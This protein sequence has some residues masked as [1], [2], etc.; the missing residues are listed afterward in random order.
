M[1]GCIEV[2]LINLYA[3]YLVQG[4][5]DSLLRIVVLD[6]LLKAEYGLLGVLQ[7]ELAQSLEVVR[8]RVNGVHFEEEVQVGYR[9]L[10][11]PGFEECYG[12]L[13]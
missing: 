1:I 13:Q 7:L 3:S 4:L 8:L 10:V 9:L 2:P 5:G 6:A 12:L 11:I